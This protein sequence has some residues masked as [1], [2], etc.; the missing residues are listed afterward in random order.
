MPN[1]H[2]SIS[3]AIPVYNGERYLAE[4]LTSALGQTHRP[5]ETLV[6]DNCSTDATREV[7]ETLIPAADVRVSA[8]NL[9]AVAN[10]NRAVTESRGTYFAWLAADDRLAPEFLERCLRAL[11]DAPEAAACLPGIR[12]IDPDGCPQEVRH[13]A[14][15]ADSRP[16]VRLRAFLRRPRWTEAYC[17]YRRD[18]LLASPMLR[19]EYGTD[20]LLTWWFLLRGPLAVVTD[21]LL[22]YRVYPQKTVAEMAATLNPQA[23]HEHWRKAR[24]WRALWRATSAPDVPRPTRRA[25]RRELVSGLCHRDWVGHLYEDVR[26]QAVS[27]RLALGRRWR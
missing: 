11:E 4:A 23:H 24:I 27:W 9:G 6:F 25:A 12:F 26:L 1:T 19:D 10:F 5:S 13:D 21:P 7:A 8:V 2:E 22:D 18:A 17:L 16:S 15:L 3:V 14:L 20:V